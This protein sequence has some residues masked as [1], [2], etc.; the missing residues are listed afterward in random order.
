MSLHLLSRAEQVANHLREEILKRRWKEHMPGV[1]HLESV[2]GVN[3]VTVNAALNLLEQQGLLE[4]QGRRRRR[5]IVVDESLLRPKTLRIRLL[6]YDRETRYSP[7]HLAV[8]DELNR[9]GF[10][11]RL[12]RKSL[13]ELGMNP[14]R[15][16]RYVNGV[17]ADAWIVSAGSSEVLAWFASQPTPALALFGAFSKVDIAGVGVRKSPMM[18]Q[19]VR[20]L[21]GLG[22]RRIVNLSHRERVVPEPALYQREFLSAMEACGLPTGPFN[23]PEWEPSREG[24][25]ECIDS[26]FTLT[27][28]TAILIDEAQ[29]FIAVQQHLASRGIL[30]PRDV[31]LISGDP[32]PS[33][34]WLRQPVT[35]MRW[36]LG[37]VVSRVTRWSRK[38][39]TGTKDRGHR[40]FHAE[41]SAGGT[42]GPVPDKAPPGD[43]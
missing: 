6:P 7:D 11:A 12:T 21:A 29:H 39:A 25:I 8:L 16:A 5:R 37:K 14:A 22:H 36:D 26:L 24:L 27:P 9:A 23:L 42:I 35:H 15:V 30:A 17:E 20:E 34:G 13:R 32:D 40:Y 4:S 38:V 33:F 28:P 41:L 19:L 3:H 2:L 31:S 10:E 18:V 1:A 43:R